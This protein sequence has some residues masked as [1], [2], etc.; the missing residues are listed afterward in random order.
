MTF[1]DEGSKMNPFNN[2]LITLQVREVTK[3]QNSLALRIVSLYGLPKRNKSIS[4]QS[5]RYCLHGANSMKRGIGQG[6]R[7]V[8]NL[9]YIPHLQISTK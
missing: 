9:H 4:V 3:S 5:P 2:V 6:Q 1:Q 7:S 8:G